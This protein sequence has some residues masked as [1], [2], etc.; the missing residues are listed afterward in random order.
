ME[1]EL[2]HE[3][4]EYDRAEMWTR[5]R[6]NKKEEVISEEARVVVKKMAEY[7]QKVVEGGDSNT[8][9]APYAPPPPMTQAQYAPPQPT[10]ASNAHRPPSQPPYAHPPQTQAP[11]APPPP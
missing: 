3:L 6:M 7:R 1:D 9:H 2:G 8:P 11:C 4:T 10:W 5:A